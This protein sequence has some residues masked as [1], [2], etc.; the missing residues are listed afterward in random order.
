MADLSHI[1]LQPVYL[2]KM[3]TETRNKIREM[4]LR[5]KVFAIVLVPSL[6]L[7]SIYMFRLYKEATQ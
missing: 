2:I 4:K 5:T 6:I 7:F 3:G 1:V